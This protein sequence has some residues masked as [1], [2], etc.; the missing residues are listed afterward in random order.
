[1]ADTSSTRTQSNQRSDSAEPARNGGES[2]PPR[3][4]DQS[5]QGKTT[6]AAT[7]VQKIAGIAAREVSGV[8]ALGGGLSRA[9]GGIRD[10]IPGSTGASQT[11]GVTVEVGEKQ[12][13]VDLNLIVEYGVSIVDL[14]K[15]V[16]AN[17]I[18]AVEHMTGLQVTEVNI[19]VNDIHIPGDEAEEPTRESRVE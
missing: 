6:I 9:F 5:S 1:M 7:V 18:G 4:A 2:S 8:H 10:R 16:R 19:A 15:S 17:I 14:A 13:A 3:L 12:A 11:S